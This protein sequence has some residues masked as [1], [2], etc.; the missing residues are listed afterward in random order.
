[1][2]KA[3]KKTKQRKPKGASPGEYAAI[4]ARC[5]AKLDVILAGVQT[6]GYFTPGYTP[7]H[8]PQ[9]TT[10]EGIKMGNHQ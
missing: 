8:M 1:M 9:V 3:T 6:R 5:E 7:W 10:H 4:L 2:K